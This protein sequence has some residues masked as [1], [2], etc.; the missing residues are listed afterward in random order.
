MVYL[1]SFIFYWDS[2]NVFR[3]E[4]VKSDIRKIINRKFI[5]NNI[6][7]PFPQIDIHMRTVA[8]NK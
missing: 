3:I 1:H 7:I 5:E 8:V 4:K 6:S 2:N